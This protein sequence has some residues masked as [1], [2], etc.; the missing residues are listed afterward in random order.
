MMNDSHRLAETLSDADLAA[1]LR[2]R[3]ERYENMYQ[4]LTGGGIKAARKKAPPQLRPNGAAANPKIK[5]SLKT[6]RNR[7][8][9]KNREDRQARGKRKRLL[10]AAT[11]N[12]WEAF[13]KPVAIRMTN[14]HRS[15]T[16]S[17][18]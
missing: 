10:R 14:D 18:D 16:H 6:P 9:P 11:P 8:S 13:T 3:I 1:I 12:Q 15:F 2:L 17:S 5:P 4:E 7:P